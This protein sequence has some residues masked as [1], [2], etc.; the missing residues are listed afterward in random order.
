M[1][2]C[3]TTYINQNDAAQSANFVNVL[4]YDPAIN[5]T[6]WIYT[7]IIE[8]KTAGSTNDLICYNGESCDFQILVNEDGHGTDT[9]TTTYY[10]WVELL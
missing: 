9:A 10:F 2:G 6:G 4:L 8:N 3:P 5:D 7:T 1:T